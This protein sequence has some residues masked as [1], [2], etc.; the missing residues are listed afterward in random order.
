MWQYADKGLRGT[1]V[2]LDENRIV[3][4]VTAL[5]LEEGLL[6]ALQLDERSR[7]VTDAAGNWL[8]YKAR[9][10][11]KLLPPKPMKFAADMGA[12]HCVKCGSMLTLLGD[13][14]CAPCRAAQD[15]LKMA[16]TGRDGER[17]GMRVERVLDPLDDHKCCMCSRLA[18]W[19]V[20]D[21]VTT[22]PEIGGPKRILGETVNRTLWDRGATVGRRWYCSWHYAPPRLLDSHA[23]VVSELPVS[24]RP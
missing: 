15:P 5:N 24:E 16:R 1:V 20:S 22:T 11:F 12:P 6:V 21:E 10:R 23:E 3:P 14:L 2:D 18:S 17:N 8:T 7:P 9:G 13:D 19:S 4:R